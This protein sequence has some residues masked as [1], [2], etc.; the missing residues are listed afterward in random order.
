MV[1]TLEK[2]L[3]P[4][5]A[6]FSVTAVGVSILLAKAN[7]RRRLEKRVQD[8]PREIEDVTNL[9]ERKSGLVRFL[10]AIGNYASH[11]RASTN[12]W[13]E[14]VRAGYYGKA[15]PAIY[16][17]AKILLLL[18]GVGSMAI[19]ILHMKISTIMKI[20]L[21]IQSIFPQC[22]VSFMISLNIGMIN[23]Y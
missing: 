23:L 20:N 2:V 15:A 3:I 19:L 7:K 13:E 8:T 9:Q 22:K 6:F 16:T 4:G 21:M 12:L 14:L 17:G 10:E 5:L 1:V 11:G 18:L